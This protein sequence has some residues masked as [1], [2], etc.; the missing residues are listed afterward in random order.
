MACIRLL[1]LLQ[2]ICRGHPTERFEIVCVI[3]DPPLKGLDVGSNLIEPLERHPWRTFPCKQ[4]RSQELATKLAA[5]FAVRFCI[6]VELGPV[7]V[8]DYLLGRYARPSK[9]RC[10]LVAIN[11]G[12]S[13]IHNCIVALQVKLE[14]RHSGS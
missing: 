12:P 11:F 4:R 7:P 8:E 6:G 9:V 3:S 10:H 14:V 2:G 13:A 5:A 1:W